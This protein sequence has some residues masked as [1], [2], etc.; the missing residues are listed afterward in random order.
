MFE[1]YQKAQSY[2]VD[3]I[4]ALKLDHL[5]DSLYA[6]CARSIMTEYREE[7]QKAFN[8]LEND[9]H[10]KNVLRY[11]EKNYSFYIRGDGFF[12]IKPF[13]SQFERNAN[14]FIVILAEQKQTTY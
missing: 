12:L 13:V 8:T 7:F 1:D 5:K 2:L 6:K 11:I 10:D 3:Y 4:E 14:N 9:N